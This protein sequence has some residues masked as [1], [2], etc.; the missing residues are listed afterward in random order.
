MA[1]VNGMLTGIHKNTFVYCCGMTA[2]QVFILKHR[3]CSAF[4]IRFENQQCNNIG[5]IAPKIDGGL[6]GNNKQ[7]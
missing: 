7:N 1:G 3:D 5:D 4:P 2:F 6:D